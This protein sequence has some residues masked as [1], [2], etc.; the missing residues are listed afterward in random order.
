MGG[1][2]GERHNAVGLADRQG[3]GVLVSCFTVNTALWGA[4]GCRRGNSHIIT[5]DKWEWS[6]LDV[7]STTISFAF[8]VSGDRFSLCQVPWPF[9]MSPMLVSSA[10][11]MMLLVL[12]LEVHLVCPGP[13]TEESMD[14]MMDV[15]YLHR[16]SKPLIWH[17]KQYFLGCTYTQG[18]RGVK[19]RPAERGQSLAGAVQGNQTPYQVRKVETKSRNKGRI[20]W[21]TEDTL[22]AQVCLVFFWRSMFKGRNGCSLH[23]CRE[24]NSEL[25][26]WVEGNFP[27]TSWVS[28]RLVSPELSLL[29]AALLVNLCDEEKNPALCACIPCWE[30]VWISENITKRWIRSW[31]WMMIASSHISDLTNLESLLTKTGPSK[32]TFKYLEIQVHYEIRNVSYFNIERNMFSI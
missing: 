11:L 30:H 5:D 13:L 8:P 25:G 29:A 20:T 3:R 27:L 31:V 16:P 15:T 17:S 32:K 26:V 21:S 1:V 2:G 24:T 28:N 4:L 10:N 19:P 18:Q 22:I 7:R 14:V 6:V 23:C 9:M 12:E